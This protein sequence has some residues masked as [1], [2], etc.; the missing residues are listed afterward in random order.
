MID[1][2]VIHETQKADDGRILHQMTQT[3]GA[4]TQP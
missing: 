2:C 1:V 3:E 4:D